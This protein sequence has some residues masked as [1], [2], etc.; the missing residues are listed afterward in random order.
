MKFKEL[1]K[2]FVDDYLKFYFD[3]ND[4]SYIFAAHRFFKKDEIAFREFFRNN[5]PDLHPLT[6]NPDEYFHL[7]KYGPH[8]LEKCPNCGRML[9]VF[10]SYSGKILCDNTNC[11]RKIS[12]IRNKE[13][14]IRKYGVSNVS[15][16]KEIQSK[17]ENTIFSKFGVSNIMLC[18]EG[19]LKQKQALIKKF[20]TSNISSLPEIKEK[21]KNT[22][23]K[24]F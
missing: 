21:K 14:C 2:Q 7:L 23:F 24:T 12:V 9:S 16:L 18:E 19:I 15:S 4:R 10:N 11:N 13:T 5:Y 3:E 22:V 20:G 8:D 1:T 17:R 6:N